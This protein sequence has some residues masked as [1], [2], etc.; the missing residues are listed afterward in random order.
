MVVPPV[1][2]IE[3]G[4]ERDLVGNVLVADPDVHAEAVSAAFDAVRD[5]DLADVTLRRVW[6]AARDTWESERSLDVG[7]IRIE[8]QAPVEVIA[9]LLSA[10]ASPDAI[11]EAARRV[12]ADGL[13][14][15][16]REAAR[17]L[18]TGS[19]AD[20]LV[21]RAELAA[22]TERRDAL[23]HAGDASRAHVWD[24]T[25]ELEREDEPVEEFIER[26][27]C[28]PGIGIAFGPPSS[29]KSYAILAA[30]FDAVMGGG[31]FCGVES[32]QIRPRRS[33]ETN[34]V[35]ER[36]LWIFGS[37]D[38]RRRVRRRIRQMHEF[39]PHYGKPV[40]KGAFAFGT[41]PPGVMLNTTKGLRW[42]SATIRER[43][44][45]IVVVDTVAS[46]CGDSLDMD[47]NGAVCA[48]MMRL[49][50]LRDE[51]QLV[52]WLLHH[53]RK[54][55]TDPKAQS[56]AKADNALGAGQWRAQTDTMVG[57][58]AID[59]DTGVVTLRVVKAKDI[60]VAPAPLRLTQEP[61]SARFRELLETDEAPVRTAAP[62]ST[63]G[64]PPAVTV[65]QVL[66]LRG[67]HPDGLVWNEAHEAL[68]VGRSTWFRVRGKLF[69][70]L[71]ARGCVMVAGRMKWGVLKSESKEERNTECHS[72]KSTSE[73][74]GGSSTSGADG[75][76]TPNSRPNSGSLQTT[77]GTSSSSP[78]QR[79]SGF[80]SSATTA[81][82]TPVSLASRDATSG[83]SG[84]TNSASGMSPN[85]SPET[86][87][88]PCPESSF[89][90]PQ[91]ASPETGEGW[92]YEPQPLSRGFGTGSVV[93]GEPEAEQEVSG[94]GGQEVV[95]GAGEDP[96]EEF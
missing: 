58:E 69:D 64:R 4:C 21:A 86:V 59:G 38:T 15:A 96:W 7:R 72:G 1:I 49:H 25:D 81:V 63:G 35:Q 3:Q 90:T 31:A 57:L 52:M 19:P 89:E 10:V 70:E 91:D 76:P 46:A 40:P 71:L 12:A 73:R 47:D 51:H 41:L 85:S 8:S 14:R 28:R 6:Q 5:L 94:L 62:R 16:E 54:G 29:G 88:K 80:A 79:P 53:S 92:G 78:S 9:G 11:R 22:L 87:P 32:L 30:A 45:T 67:K 75:R 77:S 33:F 82:G 37:E 50:K 61:Q 48:F 68:D 43:S 55:G 42:L 39:G 83:R 24:A 17:R 26:V 56:A 20:A 84:G 23:E 66:A 2:Y 95:E 93:P 60:D 65:E 44:A 34:A 74:S 18:A 27:M 36:V 13:L